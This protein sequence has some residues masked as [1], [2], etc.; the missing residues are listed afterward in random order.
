[1]FAHTE[2]HYGVNII[3]DLETHWG[4]QSSSKKL[5]LN[6]TTF[7]LFLKIKDSQNLVLDVCYAS[8]LTFTLLLTGIVLRLV[9][10]ELL[11]HL[12]PSGFREISSYNLG[13][14]IPFIILIKHLPSKVI[15]NCTLLQLSL[16][17]TTSSPVSQHLN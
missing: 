9:V 3:R 8:Y 15:P 7:T 6:Q 16:P 10:S 13:R 12:K 5:G 17:K 11:P 2:F 4:Q 1:M 14:V